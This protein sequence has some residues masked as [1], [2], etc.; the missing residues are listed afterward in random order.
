M[1]I[2]KIIIL[3]F[4]QIRPTDDFPSTGSQPVIYIL[5]AGL[6]PFIKTRHETHLQYE[7]II[8]LLFIKSRMHQHR[9]KPAIDR[10]KATVSGQLDSPT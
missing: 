8:L 5:H 10:I 2:I 6:S 1:I 4:I 7:R 3:Y 9:S